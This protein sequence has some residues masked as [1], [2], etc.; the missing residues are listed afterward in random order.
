MD[1]SRGFTFWTGLVKNYEY[2][3]LEADARTAIHVTHRIGAL[4]TFLVISWLSIRAIRS[5]AG[6]FRLYGFTTFILL[7]IQITLGI[8]NI[9]WVLPISIAVAHNGVAALLL[10]SVGSLF[11][12]SMMVLKEEK[13]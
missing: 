1:F 7:L 10:I 5:N 3:L 11:Y 13:K 6:V 2:G 8:L 12:Y 9:K 4:V